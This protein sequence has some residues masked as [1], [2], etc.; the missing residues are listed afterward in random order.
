MFYTERRSNSELIFFFSYLMLAPISSLVLWGVYLLACSNP[1]QISAFL[2]YVVG[3]YL[4][5]GYMLN[6]FK[7]EIMSAYE[8]SSK[9]VL[10]KLLL[11]LN[12]AK[13]T[14]STINC[15]F[16]AAVPGLLEQPWAS[17]YPTWF[18]RRFWRC[19]ALAGSHSRGQIPRHI[20]H[21]SRRYFKKKA[22][23][24]AYREK[25]QY[26]FSYCCWSRYQTNMFCAVSREIKC[27]VRRSI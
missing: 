24:A 10:R 2:L 14:E 8:T 23:V 6:R 17:G 16:S 26:P 1:F 27:L 22:C 25:L 7:N 3:G 13:Y 21:G 20:I 15:Y 11:S 12:L 5:E 18:S 4:A 19:A 9:C